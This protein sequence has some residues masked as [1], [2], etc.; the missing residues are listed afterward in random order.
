MKTELKYLD[1][2]AL[3]GV[4]GG[5]GLLVEVERSINGMVISRNLSSDDIA[6]EGFAE[7]ILFVFALA[8]SLTPQ[9]NEGVETEVTVSFC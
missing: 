1:D 5:T 4:A 9:D 7:T 2:K 6:A 3:L 8:G